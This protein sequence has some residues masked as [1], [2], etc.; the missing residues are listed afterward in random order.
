[1]VLTWMGHARDAAEANYMAI[2]ESDF[3][4]AVGGPLVGSTDP[5]THALASNQAPA[6]AL[7]PVLQ[8]SAIGCGADGSYLM[9]PQGLEPW[10]R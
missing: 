7:S 3:Q 9:P 2:M 8:G 5:Q 1:V 4:K 6:P 10:T